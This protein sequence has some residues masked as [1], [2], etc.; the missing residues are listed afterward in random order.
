VYV[1]KETLPL[2]QTDHVISTVAAKPNA[3]LKSI[4]MDEEVGLVM[5]MVFLGGM[6]SIAP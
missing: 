1:S 4:T 5:W 2:L 3:K 6:G